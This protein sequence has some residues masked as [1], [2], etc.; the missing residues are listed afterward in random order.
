MKDIIL[1]I[2]IGAILAIII[3]FTVYSCF[4]TILELEAL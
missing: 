4:K 1:N 2:I 3:T